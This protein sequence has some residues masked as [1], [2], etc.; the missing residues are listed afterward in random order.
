MGSADTAQSL[1]T[2]V[3]NLEEISKGLLTVTKDTQKIVT[4]VSSMF[5]QK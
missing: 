1:D 3:K 4:G 2:T 5:D